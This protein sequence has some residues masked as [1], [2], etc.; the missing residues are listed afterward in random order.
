MK[1]ENKQLQLSALVDFLK[2]LLK[3]ELPVTSL[4]EFLL[5]NIYLTVDTVNL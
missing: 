5:S 2:M 3:S 1:N 4:S